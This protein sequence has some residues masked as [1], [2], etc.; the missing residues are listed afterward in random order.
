MFISVSGNAKLLVHG[1]RAGSM[2]VFSE[3]F[4][5]KDPQT[6]NIQQLLVGEGD[7]LDIFVQGVSLSLFSAFLIAHNILDCWTT[8]RFKRDLHQ[9]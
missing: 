9:T 7:T 3:V 5:T 8:S 1:S 4:D 2:R 6:D